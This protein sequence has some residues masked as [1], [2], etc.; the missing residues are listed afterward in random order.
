[1]RTTRFIEPPWKALLSNKGLLP[2]LWEM[3]PGH[4]NLLPAFFEEDPRKAELG[5]RFA[6]KPMLSREGANV[7]LVDGAN[8]VGRTDGDYGA[9]GHIRQALVDLP[10]FDGNY[11]VIG[12]WVIGEQAAGI[13]IREDKSRIT[14][15]RSRFVPHAIVG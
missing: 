11:A 4:P 6:K 15:N 5:G 9:E 14:G 2:M 7:L 13:G 10:S 3:S 8:V 12:S 1:M